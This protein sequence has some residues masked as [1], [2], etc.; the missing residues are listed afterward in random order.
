MPNEINKV[1]SLQSKRQPILEPDK[2]QNTKFDDINL[3][4]E[5]I[6][7]LAEQLKDR[8]RQG[9]KPI[10]DEDTINLMIA[11]LRDKR[12]LI[13]RTFAQ[14]LGL[15]GKAATPGLIEVLINSKNVTARRAAA[16]TLKLVRDPASLPYLLEALLN[17]TDPVVQGSSAGAMAVFGDAAIEYLLQ[18]L[19]SPNSSSMQCGLASWALVLA[20]ADSPKRLT[21]AASSDNATIRTAAIGAL[22]SKKQSL[23]DT[24]IRSLLINAL[25]DASCEVRAEAIRIIIN[26]EEQ[27]LV[28]SL[29]IKKLKDKD[30]EARK[31]A[32]ISLMTINSKKALKQLKEIAR[33]EKEKSVI[34]VLNLAIK[35]IMNN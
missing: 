26:L 13:R 23:K 32:V 10:E 8:R 20:G 30:V 21:K 3:S 4:T 16:K 2:S 28:E 11:G 6:T 34:Q 29:L 12:G 27:N 33:S 19:S 9:A 1:L 15:T 7:Q 18:A 31:N 17:D 22:C 5:E 14:S 24:N 35:K 25:D